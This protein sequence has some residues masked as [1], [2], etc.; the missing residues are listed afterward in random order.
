MKPLCKPD[1]E[2]MLIMIADDVVLPGIVVTKL[3]AN[4]GEVIL[5]GF[6]GTDP[7]KTTELGSPVAM[8]PAQLQSH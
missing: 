6:L 3:E 7:V 2:V 1:P 4:V 5:G 8:V